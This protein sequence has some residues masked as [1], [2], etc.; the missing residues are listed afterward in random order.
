MVNAEDRDGDSPLL[1][2]LLQN[3]EDIAKYLIE[4]RKA[5]VTAFNARGDNCLWAAIQ[6]NNEPLM[7]LL[8]K[9]ER[10]DLSRKMGHYD[11]TLLMRC[12]L[13]LDHVLCD[14]IVGVILAQRPDVNI[15]N[16]LGQ[17]ALFFAVAMDR[18][19]MVTFLVAACGAL[20]KIKD[21]SG[22]TPLHFA[23]NADIAKTLIAKGAAVNASNV[24]GNT[25]LHCAFAFG[26]AAVADVMLSAGG[27]MT[28]VS[29]A[30]GRGG[31]R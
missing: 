9:D 24:Q 11:N 19:N 17:T 18:P 13:Q 10:T 7:T 27:D 31:H 20:V 4:D 8:L 3:H 26:G 15:T 25:P 12:L 2:S 23:S 30:T 1:I 21:K 14:R 29:R 5:D 6:N 22:N 28:K 16:K